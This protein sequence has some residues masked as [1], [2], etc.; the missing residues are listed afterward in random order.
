MAGHK[1]RHQILFLPHPL[2]IIKI[3]FHK[4]VK[5]LALRFSH[6]IQR[7]GRHM[8]R[9]YLQQAADM[10][11]AHFIKKSRIGVRHN[12]I[13][14]DAG[15]DKYLFHLF[16]IPDCAQNVQIFFVIHNQIGANIRKQTLPFLAGTHLHLFL[17]GHIA[18]I[19][20]RASHIMDIALKIRQPGH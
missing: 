6:I 4:A 5:H 17:A 13:K 14:P 7:I 18:E 19:T 10:E 16:Q 3:S 8:L 1:I 20:R 11:L 15:T 2:V 12:I 9:R